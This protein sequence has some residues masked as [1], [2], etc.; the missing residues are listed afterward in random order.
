MFSVFQNK[1]SKKKK[2]KMADTSDMVNPSISNIVTEEFSRGL[3]PQPAVY[4]PRYAP[5]P[6]VHNTSNTI[7]TPTAPTTTNIHQLM[8]KSWV[9]GIIV[10]LFLMIFLYRL[11]PPIVQ[12][13]STKTQHLECPKPNMR[14]VFILSF[15]GGFSVFIGPYIIRWIK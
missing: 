8:K 10:T 3:N 5:A 11:N 7:T 14:N 2:S 13:P 4:S 1:L 6:S 9:W 15:I 12:Y